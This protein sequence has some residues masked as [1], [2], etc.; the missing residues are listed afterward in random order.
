MQDASDGII[1]QLR[2]V[3]IEGEFYAGIEQ[4]VECNIFRAIERIFR[5]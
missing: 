2:R 3:E 1:I 4:S 5:L